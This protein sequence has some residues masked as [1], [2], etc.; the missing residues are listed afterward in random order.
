METRVPA[1]VFGE[2]VAPHEALVTEGA[3]EALLAGVSAVVTGQLIRTGEFLTTAGP[4][5]FKRTL[6]GV[7]P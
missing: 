6:S 2:M 4:G 7:N 5:A 1:G 3:V